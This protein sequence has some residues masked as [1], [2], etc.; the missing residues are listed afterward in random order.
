M[1]AVSMR[2]FA[3]ILNNPQLK[4][5]SHHRMAI[6]KWLPGIHDTVTQIKNK[7]IQ[8]WYGQG[9]GR[10]KYESIIKAVAEIFERELMVRNHIQI[11]NGCAVHST[12]EKAKENAI[13][14]L[15]E[16]DAFLCH[17]LTETPFEPFRQSVTV[18]NVPLSR[19]IKNLK[20]KHIDI[21]VYKMRPAV[22]C[23][24]IFIFVQCRKG[25]QKSGFQFGTACSSSYELA[26]E[27]ALVEALRSVAHYNSQI[28]NEQ[29][30]VANFESKKLKAIPEIKKHALI[31]L[32]QEYTNYF[33][34]VF[35]KKPNLK[36][37]V[38]AP[39]L[40]FDQ[41]KVKKL[42]N[43]FSDL[44]DF[45]L[46]FVHAKSSRLQPLYFGGG[47]PEKINLKRLKIFSS[48]SDFQFPN[49]KPH[50]FS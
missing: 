45:P 5:K 9:W 18:F 44:K 35:L 47:N 7:K 25:P 31:R 13:Y 23:A 49:S 26:I 41:I 30:N 37:K 42:E 12:I 21:K 15:I 33:K 46:V 27:H 22:S 11:S 3:W 8:D 1:D 38:G 20:K 16:R 19:L 43:K 10:S 14:E 4:L 48:N 32:D 36:E 2:F 50:P 24:A 29:V 34:K 28:K 39:I 17:F 6:S 40:K